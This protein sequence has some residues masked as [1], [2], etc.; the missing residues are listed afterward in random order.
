MI[1]RRFVIAFDLL[2]IDT[3]KA[4]AGENSPSVV[5]AARCI[6]VGLF[7]SGD[8]R[9]D[10]T[11]SMAIGEVDDFRVISFPGDELRRVSPD[12]RSIS[13]FLAKAYSKL[14]Q[15]SDNERETMSNGIILERTSL[16][17]IVEDWPSEKRYL[18]ISGDD[19]VATLDMNIS[20]GLFVYGVNQTILSQINSRF[21]W[22]QLNRP[23]N[24]ERFILEVNLAFDKS[25]N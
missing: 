12:E 11:I 24:P 6:N 9:I 7:V 22:I 25:R 4:K 2:E 15:L 21:Q 1:R 17:K 8:L 10:T 23:K 19:S 13:L 16:G 18:S 3:A 14:V 20:D 5:T